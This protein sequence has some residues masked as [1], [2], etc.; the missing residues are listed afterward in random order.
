MVGSNSL[1]NQR[2]SFSYNSRLYRLSRGLTS[3]VFFLG[4]CVLIVVSGL[5]LLTTSNF[6][7]TEGQPYSESANI[8]TVHTLP[9]LLQAVVVLLCGFLIAAVLFLLWKSKIAQVKPNHLLLVV[10][11]WAFI[12]QALWITSLHT[13]GYMYPDSNELM[14]SAQAL[15]SGD[16]DAFT[17][18]VS[19]VAGVTNPNVPDPSLYFT[20]YPYQAGS[21]YFFALLEQ[22]FGQNFFMGFQMVN[23]CANCITIY[24]LYKLAAELHASSRAQ[25]VCLV[26]CGT[27]FPL[28]FSCVFVYANCVGLSLS[29]AAFVVMMAGLN[30][31][32]NTPRL[33]L[34]L[35]SFILVT[36]AVAVKG[37]CILFLIAMVFTLLVESAHTRSLALCIVTIVCAIASP[38]FSGLPLQALQTQTSADFGPGMSRAAWIAMGLRSDNPLGVPGWWGTHAIE[39]TAQAN[40]DSELERQIALE[41]IRQSLTTYATHPGQGARFF[42]V[43]LASEWADPTF[44]SLY[45]ASLCRSADGITSNYGH[46][47][48]TVLYGRAHNPALLFMDAYQLII[49]IPAMLYCLRKWRGRKDYL[50]VP[51]GSQ[52]A[53][54]P[55]EGLLPLSISIGFVVYVLWE[56]KSIYLLPFFVCM[57]PLAAIELDHI[58]K[59][60]TFRFKGQ[61]QG[62]K[63]KQL[64]RN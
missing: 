13:G 7:F 60:I 53:S 49:V 56:A 37:T 40:G 41:D 3:F 26:L 39:I 36:I 20:W 47:A 15:L 32:K 21:L 25:N 55:V 30:K 43:K 5:V 62:K 51:K 16:F 2:C 61:N 17:R 33:L 8:T 46:F 29:A 44:Q 45:Y 50:K 57:L 48:T 11:I 63:S 12:F 1:K 59:R 52:S 35:L 10:V 58:F 22:I 31:T 54:S 28:L 42:G 27:C 14:N 6:L 38:Q 9:G 64:T 4:L 23:A 19:Y 24:C 34:I 18:D